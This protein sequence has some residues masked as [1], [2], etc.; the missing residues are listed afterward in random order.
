MK[1]PDIP[2]LSERGRDPSGRP[3]SLNR[4]LFMQLLAFSRCTALS[5]LIQSLDRSDLV[6][7]LYLDVSDPRGVALITAHEDP[8]FFTRELRDFL[9][10]PE[11]R[12]LEF[13]PE[14]TMFG[15]T[16]AV[17][18]E[19]NLEHVLFRRP[20]SRIAN[21]AWPWAVWY[22]LRRA[23]AFEKLSAEEQ[24]AI[25]SEHG[26]LGSS[27]SAGDYGYDIRLACHGLDKND[28]DFVIGLVGKELYPLSAMVQAMRKTRQTSE[29]LASLG[30][31]FIG[32]AIWQ[33]GH[34][35]A[36]QQ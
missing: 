27:F 3:I 20:I 11:W 5:D 2:D 30:P 8:A 14:Y 22:P 25:M 19:P 26:T 4:R 1:K 24:R 16:Y 28:N 35:Q 15:R 33:S 23:G 7:A 13:K 31:F 9:S 29:F 12:E 21:P 10:Q 18:Y 34:S 6:G 32:R 36:Q 17:G